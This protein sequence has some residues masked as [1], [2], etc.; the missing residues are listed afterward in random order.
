MAHK[1]PVRTLAV[2]AD[3]DNGYSSRDI[4]EDAQNRNRAVT[5]ACE[6]REAVGTSDT[7]G[8]CDCVCPS[9]NHRHPSSRGVLGEAALRYVCAAYLDGAFDSPLDLLFDL[10]RAALTEAGH[11]WVPS[12][13]CTC[14]ACGW[15][16]TPASH[17]RWGLAARALAQGEQL[18]APGARSEGA[19]SPEHD[20]APDPAR[21][22]GADAARLAPA[23]DGS[24]APA[25]ALTAAA[26]R[27][28]L[29]AF[30]D[31]QGRYGGRV[32][33]VAFLVSLEDGTSF[34]LFRGMPLEV[35]ARVM[36]GIGKLGADELDRQARGRGR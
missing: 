36:L 26:F 7:G 9:C 29:S 4:S 30:L 5:A 27:E 23:V 12:L 17:V 19:G 28:E 18:H 6:E 2:G 35:Q 24:A 3:A 14:P 33:V 10:S 20:R 1:R 16:H 13:A 34:G 15:C 25:P 21:V 31:G 32:G 11:G 8:P 22:R